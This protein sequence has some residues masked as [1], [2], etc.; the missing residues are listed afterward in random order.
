[1]KRLCLLGV[2]AILVNAAS[3]ARADTASWPERPV[4]IINAYPPG[5]ASD[6]ITRL[7]AAHLTTALGQTFVVV[8]RPG[9]GGMIGTA[10]AAKAKN[11]GY[12]LLL[13]PSGPLATALPFFKQIGF[14]PVKDF[15]AVSYV[16][17]YEMAM[18]TNNQT[19]F[20]TVAEL[21][22]YAKANPGKVR[23]AVPTIGGIPHLTSE[24]FQWKAGLQGIK[25]PY[26]GSSEA[27]ADLAAGHIDIDVDSLPALMQMIQGDRLRPLAV[28]AEQRLEVLPHVPTFKEL[29][30]PELV[31]YAWLALLAPAGTPAPII[32]KLT[33][34]MKQILADPALGAQFRNAGAHPEWRSAADTDRFIRDEVARWQ[35]VVDDADVRASFPA[36]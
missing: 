9:A 7:V 35:K 13:S 6:N 36:Q 34:T 4:R 16:G 12:T 17:H 18:V 2:I 5:G 11:D 10:A 19:P 27:I 21:A 3:P 8:N 20:K 32:D 24:L 29:G 22:A 15:A 14:D 31:A 33:R 25:V 23:F 26:K 30:Y 1:M 28:T